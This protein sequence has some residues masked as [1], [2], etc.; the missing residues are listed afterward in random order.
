MAH[1]HPDILKVFADRYRSS[2]A[3]RTGVHTGDFTFD[4][5]KLLKAAHADSAEAR[6]NAEDRLRQA[7]SQS[8]EKLELKTHLHDINLIY[9]VRLSREGGEAWLFNHLRESSPTEERRQLAD[10]FESYQETLVPPNYKDAWL[11]W[12]LRLAQHAFDGSPVT[13]FTRDDLAE[14]RELLTVIPR[15]LTWQGE[16]LIRF[17]SCT[18]CGDSKRLEQLRPRLESSLRQITDGR[19]QSLE[20]LGLMEKP[21]RVFL[22]GPLRLELPGG[23][24]DLGWLH[25]PV[26]ISETDI[27][28]TTAIHCDASQVLTVENETTFLELA[29]L[30]SDTLLIQTSYPGRA[31]LALLACL[32]ANLPIHHFGDTDPAGFDILRDL[33][34]RSGRTI[35]P[36]H[37]HHR[38]L[39]DS[40]TLQP[41][42]LQIIDRLLADPHMA[43]CHPPLQAMRDSGIKGD[44]EQESLGRPS[45]AEWPFYKSD[46]NA[47]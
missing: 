20:D 46:W 14:A 17:A 45:L 18:I 19:I 6:N 35:Q 26:S 15:V 16:S 2:R 40:E 1:E 23:T 5:R 34:S 9:L 31:V 33:R 8:Q 43:D 47:G 13:P 10:L 22:R 39:R 41:L 4:Y 36:L 24:L 27:H 11:S 44:F 25:S 42:D 3:G 21:R 29:K 38:P 32:P 12:C 30:N 37:M 7:A 28:H